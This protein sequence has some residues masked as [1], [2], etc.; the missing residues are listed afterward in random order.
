MVFLRCLLN[1][2]V[3]DCPGVSFL[4]REHDVQFG[5][6]SR[7]VLLLLR[8]HVVDGSGGYISV[9]LDMFLLVATG[10]IVLPFCPRAVD[11]G[12][13]GIGRSIR[14]GPPRNQ[15]REKRAAKLG[16]RSFS[17]SVNDMILHLKQI[18]MT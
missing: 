10:L 13:H 14:R 7:V 17:S 6:D 11:A 3:V 9:D 5:A 1:R 16:Q 15:K 4:P 12:G 18:L 2:V 8:E